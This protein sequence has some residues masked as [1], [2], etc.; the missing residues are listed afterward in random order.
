MNFNDKMDIILDEYETNLLEGSK[1]LVDDFLAKS[2]EVPTGEYIIKVKDKNTC[3]LI[4]SNEASSDQFEIQ[5]PTLAGFF[6]PNVHIK[7][8]NPRGKTFISD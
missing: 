2:F 1:I 8:V 3:I 5:R 4:P 7:T 6:N